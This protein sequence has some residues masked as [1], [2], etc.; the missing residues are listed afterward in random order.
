MA[1]LQLVV[2]GHGEQAASQLLIRRIL[3]E[4]LE[5]YAS[6]VLRPQ[7]RTSIPALLSRNGEALLRYQRVAELDG[8]SV[9]WLLDHDDGCPL[10]SLREAYEIFRQEGVAK[11]TAIA[12]LCREYESLFLEDANCCESYYKVPAG[13]FH[14]GRLAR[15]AKGHISKTLPRG[16]TYKPTVDQAPLTAR[17]D[18]VRLQ[19]VSRS[20]RHLEATL[21]WLCSDSAMGLY[22]ITVP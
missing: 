12:F 8:D 14:E 20:Y 6:A 22:P 21:R 16:T 3:H 10:D 5:D 18:L 7:R 13:L 17:L 9:L 4:R 11:P 1:L 15:D 2:E 19:A